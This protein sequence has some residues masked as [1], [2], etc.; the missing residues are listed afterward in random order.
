MDARF[1]TEVCVVGGGPAGASL[2]LRLARLGHSV[3]LMERHAFPRPHVGESLAPGVWPLLDMLGVAEEVR[4][5]SFLPAHEALVRWEDGTGRSVRSREPGLLVDRGRFDALL[6]GAARD[7]GVRV[8]QPAA[9]HRPE[10]LD[11]GWRVP[12]VLSGGRRLQVSARFLADASGRG[13]W[14]GGRKEPVSARTVALHGYWRGERPHGP[15][16]RVEAGPDAW[17]WGAHLPD[18]TF[19]AMAFVD[20]E[21]LRER[22]VTRRTLESFYLELLASS[23]LLGAWTSPRLV[24]SVLVS[25]ATCYRD[26]V[27]IERDCIKVGEASFSID[28]LSSSGVQKALQTALSGAVAVHTLLVRPDNASAA[29]RFYTEDQRESVARHAAWAAGY[30]AEHRTYRDRPFWKCRAQASPTLGGLETRPPP[31][32]GE[33]LLH[34]R[35]RL[36]REVALVDT[37]CIVGDLIELRRALSHPRLGRPVAWLDGVELAPL[38]EGL[39]DGLTMPQLADT[40]GREVPFRRGVAILGWLYRQGLLAEVGANEMR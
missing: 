5:A 10:R 7:A 6:L 36:D 19:S 14:L 32:E 15:E 12:V 3:C 13:T 40:W 22:G 29:L 39:R 8:L 25:D 11:V 4:R 34:R 17:Y 31:L 33:A 27:P 18:G 24:G 38:V 20:P 37:P 16:T 28:P 30:Y 1:D 26:A 23:G 35:W 9:A 21:L 2:A